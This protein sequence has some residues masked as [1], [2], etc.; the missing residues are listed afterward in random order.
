MQRVS[1]NISFKRKSITFEKIDN[2]WEQFEAFIILLICSLTKKRE[3]YYLH[4]CY[5]ENKKASK[6]KKKLITSQKY[7]GANQCP[8]SF[9]FAVV[10]IISNTNIFING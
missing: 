1:V 4:I 5:E 6:L 7:T 9:I 2:N 8:P 10:H 3:N